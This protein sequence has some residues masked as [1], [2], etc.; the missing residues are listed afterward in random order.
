MKS[1][2]GSGNAALVAN[3]S[4]WVCPC[5][6]TIGRSRTSLNS[7]C[8]IARVA[9]SAGNSR[10]SCRNCRLIAATILQ[11][12]DEKKNLKPVTEDTEE[13]ERSQRRDRD[14]TKFS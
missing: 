14:F 10:L 2:A 8:A 3:H 13:K 11:R 6:L 9:E 1:R 5:G 4:A 12:Q 7:R